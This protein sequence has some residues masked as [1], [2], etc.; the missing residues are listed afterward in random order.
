MSSN[1]EED[2]KPFSDETPGDENKDKEKKV[3]KSIIRKPQPK[4]DST[5]YFAFDAIETPISICLN[6]D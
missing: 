4:L 5:R 6:S 3:R 1:D 2:M